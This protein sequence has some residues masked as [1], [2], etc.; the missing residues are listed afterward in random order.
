MTWADVEAKITFMTNGKEFNRETGFPVEGGKELPPFSQDD[1][2]MITGAMREVYENSPAAKE[3][4]DNYI[5]AGNEITIG[6]AP[7]THAVVQ[8]GDGPPLME[9]DLADLK[10]GYYT[11]PTGEKAPTTPLSIVVHELGHLVGGL[12]GDSEDKG[13]KSETSPREMAPPEMRRLPLAISPHPRTYRPH[14]RSLPG[15]RRSQTQGPKRHLPARC[16]IWAGT[17]LPYRIWT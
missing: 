11:T 6:A 1:M 9:L 8:Y 17:P 14:H 15:R 16:R 5:D 12:P 13:E 2:G 7:G 3:I 4:F 10:D